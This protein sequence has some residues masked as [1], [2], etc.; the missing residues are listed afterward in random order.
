MQHPRPGQLQPL[1]RTSGSLT[2]EQNFHLT[3][4]ENC[5]NNRDHR[6]FKPMDNDDLYDEELVNDITP[7]VLAVIRRDGF[8]QRLDDYFCPADASQ[9]RLRCQGSFDI[10]IG[11][12]RD[13]GIDEENIQDVIEVLHAK[14]AC[15]DCEVLYNVAEE[16]RLKSEY[17]L[18][19]AQGV[20]LSGRQSEAHKS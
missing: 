1:A 14:G 10:S 9:E 6:S 15:C 20:E 19:R 5:P 4:G 2:E 18:A 13:I 3:I 7:N 12:L 17:W 8:F 16:S 11:I